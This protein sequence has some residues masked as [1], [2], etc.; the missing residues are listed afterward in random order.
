MEKISQH[1]RNTVPVFKFTGKFSDDLPMLNTRVLITTFSG[2]QYY[3]VLIKSDEYP[4]GFIYE[5]YNDLTYRI[6]NVKSW[7][8]AD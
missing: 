3:A 6:Y 7:E 2:N 4:E 8:Y 1:K 5:D